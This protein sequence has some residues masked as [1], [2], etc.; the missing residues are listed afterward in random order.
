MSRGIMS[1]G[2][3]IS[4][5]ILMAG[6]LLIGAREPE[7]GPNLASSSFDLIESAYERQEISYGDRI[8]YQL[9]AAMAPGDLPEKFTGERIQIVKSGT[10]L[11]NQVLDDWDQLSLNQQ[12]WA[13]RYLSRPALDSEYISPDGVF[14]I[15]Y[16][17]TTYDS[18]PSE[19]LDADGVPD[20]VERIGQYADSA[21]R[22]YHVHSGYLLPP[23]DGDALCDIYLVHMGVVYGAT[24]REGAGE[25]EWDDYVSY[26]K[27]NNTFQFAGENDDPEGRIIGAQKVTSVH[28][29]FH[30]VQMAYSYRNGPDLWWTE[31]TAVFHEDVVYEEVND[32][33]SYLPYFFNYPDTFLI[34]TSYFATYHDYSTFIW[35]S[36]LAEKYGNGVIKSVWEYLR[37]Y[38][39]LPSMDSSLVSYGATVRMIFPEF[40][41]WNY[42]TGD[43]GDT[44]FH[45]D[46]FDYPSILIDTVLN[47]PFM[48]LSPNYPPDGLASSYILAYPSGF[49][50]GLLHLEFDGNN[51]VEW[52]FSYVTFKDGEYDLTV[53]CEVN[54][55]GI[56]DCGI[57]DFLQYD[58]ILFIPCIISPWQD[59][60]NYVFDNQIFPFGDVNGNGY[61]NI[62][63][64][65]RLI[66]YIYGGGLPPE[67]DVLMGDADCNGLV[68]LLDVVY[69]I[70]TLYHNGPL[71]CEDL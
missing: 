16:S 29:Y 44:S 39:I 46:G 13:T 71:P 57:Y 26:I 61:L 64:I 17:L 28:E 63:D 45:D 50:N 36:F 54:A 27:M 8:F 48:F 10:P 33:Y 55:Q 9:Q 5:L 37:Y 69:L 51:D 59:D 15:H 60:N 24:F 30:V 20:Y 7:S 6:L 12:E 34:D 3:S 52:S 31:G 42:F 14:L 53:G 70:N 47:C 22:F 2:Y 58:S 18:V 21:F 19:D 35:P 65:T 32:N 11:V 62:L 67:Y 23:S 1:K 56:T 40:T 41:V 66:E 38:D 68:N 25:Y 43:R 49:G 4:L